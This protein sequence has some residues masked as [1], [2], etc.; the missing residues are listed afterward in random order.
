MRP[1]FV[2]AKGTGLQFRIYPALPRGIVM[3]E[4]TGTICGIPEEDVTVGK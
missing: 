3:D 1:V 4:T 2:S